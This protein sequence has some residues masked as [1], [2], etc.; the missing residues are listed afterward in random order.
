MF[1]AG[2]VRSVMLRNSLVC[3]VQSSGLPLE[4]PGQHRG[5]ELSKREDTRP[6]V[7]LLNQASAYSGWY[8]VRSIAPAVL[9]VEVA[10]YSISFPLPCPS[11]SS[12]R[13]GNFFSSQ[14]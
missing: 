10:H 1:E 6:D 8:Q 12:A 9:F 11:R 5:F 13:I 2:V 14:P 7:F 4:E 3:D